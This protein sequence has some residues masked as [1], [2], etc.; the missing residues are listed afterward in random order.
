MFP[1]EGVTG[2]CAAHQ[3][4]ML[5]DANDDRPDC[6]VSADSNTQHR[7]ATRSHKG[8][9]SN[10]STCRNVCN[11]SSGA[12]HESPSSYCCEGEP[13]GIFVVLCSDVLGE[14][15]TVGANWGV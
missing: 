3:K 11:T 1:P 5:E 15:I 9:P 7:N 2:A 14:H 12:N 4:K 13:R 6:A 8:T 10:K